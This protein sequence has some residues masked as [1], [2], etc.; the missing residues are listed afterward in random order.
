LEH[1]QPEHRIASA[2]QMKRHALNKINKDI[3]KML[4]INQSISQFSS[5]PHFSTK[6][7]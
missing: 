1:F 4:F 6:S 5:T 7:I 2:T 3:S